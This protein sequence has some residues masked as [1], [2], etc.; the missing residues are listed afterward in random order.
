MGDSTS[1]QGTLADMGAMG[2]MMGAGKAV[3]A[4][5]LLGK[6]IGKGVGAGK[7]RRASNNEK[8]FEV[9]SLLAEKQGLGKAKYEMDSKGKMKFAGFKLDE[10]MKG[11]KDAFN[12][13]KFDKKEFK[14]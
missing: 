5:A 9:K 12:S 13:L 14:L 10:K 8:K 11:S 7:K 4:V 3:G 6:G 1:L 2:A